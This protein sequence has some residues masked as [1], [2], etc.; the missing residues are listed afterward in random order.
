MLSKKTLKPAESI[1][2]AKQEGKIIVSRFHEP[3][4]LYNRLNRK[5][6]ASRHKK[7]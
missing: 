7:E 1:E 2:P 5:Y 4:K 3:A 6:L